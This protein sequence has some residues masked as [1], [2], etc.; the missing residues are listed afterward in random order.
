MV[1]TKLDAL[2]PANYSVE[3][4]C[5]TLKEIPIETADLDER[6]GMEPYSEGW[7][8]LVVLKFLARE[9]LRATA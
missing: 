1:T 6:K 8:E 2:V 4:L 3:R 7:V 5:S 9:M